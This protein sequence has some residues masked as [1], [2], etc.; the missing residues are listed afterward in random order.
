MANQTWKQF[1][2]DLAKLF[3][4]RRVPLSGSNSGHDTRADLMFRLDGPSWMYI[5]AKRSKAYNKFGI[6]NYDEFTDDKFWVWKF[7]GR[8]LCFFSLQFLVKQ[9]KEPTLYLVERMG[10]V[11]ELKN[12]R[13]VAILYLKTA[14]LASAEAKSCTLVCLRL[15]GLSKIVCVADVPSFQKL[16]EWVACNYAFQN[17]VLAGGRKSLFIDKR[18]P[19]RIP[20]PIWDQMPQHVY[21]NAKDHCY[22]YRVKWYDN[23]NKACGYYRTKTIAKSYYLDNLIAWMKKNGYEVKQKEYMK[24][25]V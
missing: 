9:C 1:E 3:G 17:R 5:E 11:P 10:V 19:V 13:R 25:R 18:D 16:K 6:D 8:V 7:S 4:G 24:A 15:H 22:M 2:R 20:A 14:E 23:K 12:L 21:W